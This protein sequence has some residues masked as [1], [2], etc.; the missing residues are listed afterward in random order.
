[1]MIETSCNIVNFLCSM[2]AAHLLDIFLGKLIYLHIANVTAKPAK[3][4][5][6]MEDAYASSLP[7]GVIH[8]RYDELYM[9]NN[10][11]DIST[12]C[13]NRNTADTVVKPVRYK[14]QG[15]CDEQLDHHSGVE[16][17]N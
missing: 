12:K 14:L 17:Q 10:E 2:T 7:A 15:R 9:L 5:K 6:V 11:G 16:V 3:W 4:A 8:A 13:H 1:M